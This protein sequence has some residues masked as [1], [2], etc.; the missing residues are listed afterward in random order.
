MSLI[1]KT[2]VK[3]RLSARHRTEIHLEP[4]I[5]AD[6]TGFPHDQDAGEGPRGNDEP[7]HAASVP[8]KSV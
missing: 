7:E 8:L 4:A 6:A 1:K 2:D 5:Q 3:N